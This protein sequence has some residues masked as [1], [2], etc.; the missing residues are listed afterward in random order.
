[1]PI[2]LESDDGREAA[3]YRGGTPL[4]RRDTDV[5]HAVLIGTL[6]IVVAAAIAVTAQGKTA[7]T[8]AY[9]TRQHAFAQVDTGKKGFSIGDAFIFSEQLLQNGK[10]VGYDHVVCTHA[11]DWPSSA[12]SCAG[13]AVLANGTL[14]LGG[15]SK[16]GPFTLAVLGGTGSY[17]GSRGTAKVTSQGE[18]G[19]LTISLL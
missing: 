14:Q 3:S 6:V 17:A 11:A 16:R 1:M 8:L 15:L 2:L 13:T 12:E 9:T 4:D 5:N 19:T 18:K 10:Q 7:S